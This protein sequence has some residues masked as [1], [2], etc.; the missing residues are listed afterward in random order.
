MKSF[1]AL[2]EK[3]AEMQKKFTEEGSK[4]FEEIC[5]EV[6]EA[7]PELYSFSWTQYTPYFA[8][9]DECIFGVNEVSRINGFSDYDEDEEEDQTTESGEALFNIFEGYS[10]DGK[11][12]ETKIVK[13]LNK[14][15]Q[16][17]PDD[18]LKAIY[19]DHCRV[20][21]YRD[22]AVNVEEYEHD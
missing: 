8:D 5:K 1:D 11:N 7:Y 12:R 2:N 3:L 6:F 13:E 17:A 14:F 16:S 22:K 15:I 19:G 10:Y 4:L 21:I 18:I 9:G 20:T